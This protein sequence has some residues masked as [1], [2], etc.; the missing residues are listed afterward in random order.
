MEPVTY[1]PAPQAAITFAGKLN[2]TTALNAH[3]SQASGRNDPSNAGRWFIAC[4]AGFLGWADEMPWPERT[5]VSIV[6]KLNKYKEARK[7][8]LSSGLF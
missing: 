6:I 7:K 1:P 4:D 2:H 8:A 5:Q 3:V